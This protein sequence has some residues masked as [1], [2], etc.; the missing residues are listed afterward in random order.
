MSSRWANTSNCSWPTAASTSDESPSRGRVSTC[1][2][3]SSSSCSRP[4][5]NCF[6][7]AGVERAGRG[8]HLGRERRD[9]GEP[10]RRVRLVVQRV[11]D[12]ETGGVDESDDVAGERLLDG[13]ALGAEHGRRV[14]GG[15]RLAGA[16]AGHHHAAVEPA[17]ADA[18]ERDAVAVGRSM[19]A[20]TLNTNAEHGSSRGRGLS[21]TSSRAVGA[22]AR[23][24]TASSRCRTPKSVS[25]D[26]ANTG[27]RLA[28]EERR[29]VDVG[30]DRARA[31]PSS[32]VRFVHAA[33]LLVGGLLGGRR[34]PR[35]RSCAPR[36]VR[37]KRLNTSVRRSM[38]PRKSP[39][40]RPARWPAWG[41]GRSAASISS[42]SS[43]GSRPGRSNLLRKVITGRLRDAA[44]LEQLERLG[45][46]A[47]G[48][49]EHHHDR[50]DGREHPV[51][52][53]G[54]VA[55]ARRV[56]QVELVVAVR[57]L[58]RR[59][60]DRDATLLLHAPSSRDVAARRPVV[61]LDGATRR[62]RTRVEQELLG[63]RGLAGVGV[64]DD[65]ER[66]TTR[67]F[68]EHLGRHLFEATVGL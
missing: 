38:T 2:T 39:S 52:V 63:E 47:L 26:P 44:H 3:P 64:A 13:R 48:G 10:D 61:G 67:R 49:V 18:G 24:T 27:V 30:A 33:A 1:T 54:E 57:E 37:V 50:V 31:A 15:E 65:R 36:A 58:Q 51:G 21:S 12:V 53:L 56:E 41:A 25:A 35:A 34:P 20:C 43:S 19:L 68:A 9:R 23:S 60:G 22:G 55:V 11:A 5:R 6:D 4:L 17:A 42:S 28:G 14:L 8:E 59:R 40:T 16:V 45:L 62:D 7:R 66:A 46:D 29:E 32:S